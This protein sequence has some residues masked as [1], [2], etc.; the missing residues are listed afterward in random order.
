MFADSTSTVA[1]SAA[2]L[3]VAMMA[4]CG[5]NTVHA[6]DGAQ[7][8][9][10]E[11]LLACDGMTDPVEKMACFNAVVE[12]LKESPAAPAAES[13]TAVAPDSIAPAVIAPAAGATAAATPATPAEPAVTSDTMVDNFGLDGAR[14]NTAAQK[15]EKKKDEF[16][17]V[18]ATIVRTWRIVDPRLADDRFAVELDNGQVWQATEMHRVGLPKVG[19]SVEILKGRFGGYR[20]KIDGIK[21]P[22]RVR[23]TK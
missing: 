16:R 14:T 17:S 15:E 2:T 18:Q 5:F 9:T 21:K 23:R 19:R 22:A 20:M 3:A 8:E 12:N 13:P 6:Q 1:K 4:I 10:N 11:R 7:S